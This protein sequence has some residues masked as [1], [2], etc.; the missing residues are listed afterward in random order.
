MKT[1]IV[2][3]S[4]TEAKFFEYS[5]SVRRSVQYL[6]KLE[7]PRGRLRAKEINSDKPGDFYNEFT[8]HGTSLVKDE[9]PTE[10]VAQEFAKKVVDY[11]DFQHDQK[12]FDDLVL[13]S[14]PHFMGRLRGLLPR[15]IMQIVK[16][17]VLKDLSS[18]TTQELQD[19]LWPAGGEMSL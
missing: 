18:V 8:F 5:G 17:E 9:S 2:V 11:I 6:S 12:K 4:R 10:R 16:K 13:V 7:N 3:A 19:R 15:N 14:D 1:W